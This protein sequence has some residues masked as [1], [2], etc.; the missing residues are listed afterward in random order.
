VTAPS[1]LQPHSPSVALTAGD[2][3]CY[4]LDNAALNISNRF[5]ATSFRVI[6]TDQL[7]AAIL[8]GDTQG[9][10]TVVRTDRTIYCSKLMLPEFLPLAL[11]PL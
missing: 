1:S 6:F 4:Y 11:P 7:I 10:L 5:C 9:I 8:D 2:S 3:Y